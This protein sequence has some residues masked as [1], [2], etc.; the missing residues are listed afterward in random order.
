MSELKSFGSDVEDAISRVRVPAY[1]V[2]KHGIIRWL[3]PAA[4]KLVGDVRGRQNTSVVAPEERRRA[5]SSSPGTFSDHQK[6]RTTRAC[7]STRMAS[8]CP[9]SSARFHFGA[10]GT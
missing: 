7:S 5:R 9:S 4:Q 3:N 1:L 6:A 10:V 2:D 8:E